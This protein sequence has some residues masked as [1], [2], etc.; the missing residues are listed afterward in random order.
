[1]NEIIEKIENINSDAGLAEL[2]SMGILLA[3]NEELDDFKSRTI[4]FFKN[5]KELENQINENGQAE[6]DGIELRKSQIISK[7]YFEDCDKI[8][9]S[10][11]GFSIDWIPAFFAKKDLGLLCGGCSI[12][13]PEKNISVFLIREPFKKSKKWLIYNVNELLSHELCHIAR[14]HLNENIYEEQFAYA[15]SPSKFRQYIG[16][17]FQSGYETIIFLIPM[18]IMLIADFAKILYYPS[19]PTLPFFVLAFIYPSF[20]LI[21]N[22][23]YRKI[24]FKALNNIK[25]I[26]DKPNAIL[27]RSTA[28]E[29]AEFAQTGDK[30]ILL[31]QIKYKSENELR[32]KVIK[33]RFCF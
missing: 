11:Y 24:F 23:I 4:E 17:C 5:I 15:I 26:S 27:F 6:I 14:Q 20:L 29:I 33:N 2:D 8:T 7:D 21:R 18:F 30:D 13:F 12:Y 3:P 25:Q 32:W 19:L 16:N 9:N 10:A 31:S 28:D 1:M 22:H